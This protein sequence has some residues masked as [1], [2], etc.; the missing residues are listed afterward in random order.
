LRQVAGDPSSSARYRD[1]LRPQQLE[2]ELRIVLRAANE[3]W[4][5]VS[6][7]R[8]D[9]SRPF[10]EEETRIAGSLSEPLGDVL[11]K[12]ARH[13][14]DIAIGRRPERPG[15]MLFGTD[16]AL[17]SINDAARMWL[18]ELPDDLGLPSEFGVDVPFW[19]LATVFRARALA[20]EGR[21]GTARARVRTRRATWLVCHGSCLL[22]ATGVG[23]DTA[24]V[25][26]PAKG[27]DVAPIIVQAYD[28][29]QREQEITRMVA[30]GAATNEIAD[31]L[32]L[33]HHTVRDHIKAIFSKVG[34]SS[35]GEL[36][37]T[38]FADHYWPEH[39]QDVIR[40]HD[41]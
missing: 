39:D 37:A 18:D 10:S 16:G 4:G 3:P 13:N 21:T 7:W 33:S 11:R 23:L 40:I 41:A 2:D 6:L 15:V 22:D 30:R 8:R 19:M 32:F 31:E 9:R 17:K 12:Q 27:A 29:T 14:G 20:D 25:L 38:L 36:V 26:E 34:V 24:L 5:V 1:F 28:L 35:R